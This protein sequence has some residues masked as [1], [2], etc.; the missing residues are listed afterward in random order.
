MLKELITKY[1]NFKI[2]TIENIGESREGIND[3]LEFLNDSLI[4][5][6]I[7]YIKKICKK[8]NE[9]MEKAQGKDERE[10]LIKKKN[11]YMTE[12]AILASNNLKNIDFSLRIIDKQ[13]SIY[14]CLSALKNY[15]EENIVQA[16]ELF[17]GYFLENKYILEHYLIS[18]VYGIILYDNKDYVNAGIFLRK[19][20]E[21]RPED[22]EIHKILKDI[23][24]KNNDEIMMKKEED[25]LNL[26]EEG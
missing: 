11:E 15:K 5:S 12:I 4:A 8:V 20:I 23:Y 22:I 24:S 1:N 7:E 3:E 2:K 19:A 10:F 14:K 17:E 21:K 13:N 25:I 16:K 18:K 26:L 9:D 6:K